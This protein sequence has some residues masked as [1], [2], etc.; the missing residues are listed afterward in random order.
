MA[1]AIPTRAGRSYG[2]LRVLFV[3][4][5]LSA[6]LGRVGGDYDPSDISGFRQDLLDRYT[7][8]IKE[9]SAVGKSWQEIEALLVAEDAKRADTYLKQPLLNLNWIRKDG[10]DGPREN[11]DRKIEEIFEDLYRRLALDLIK[12]ENRRGN[13]TRPDHT[14]D[15]IRYVANLY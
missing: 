2:K 13:I 14:L 6:L 4:S 9:L 5:S 10:A 11:A 3:V 1:T 7:T 15:I 8:R 12:L